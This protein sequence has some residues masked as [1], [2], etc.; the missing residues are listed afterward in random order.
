M[1]T[2]L[3]S[4]ES[5]LFN[6]LSDWPANTHCVLPLAGFQTAAHVLLQQQGT[7]MFLMSLWRGNS[8][9]RLHHFT[10]EPGLIPEDEHTPGGASVARGRGQKHSGM[11]Y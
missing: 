10:R 8:Q 1:A 7:V 9:N 11:E 6:P 5:S 3:R 4:T 2:Y